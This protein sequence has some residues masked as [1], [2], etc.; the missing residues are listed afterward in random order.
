[1]FVGKNVDVDGMI[2]GVSVAPAEGM[3][4]GLQDEVAIDGDVVGNNVRISEGKPFEGFVGVALSNRV[5]IFV[6]RGVD[7]GDTVGSAVKVANV[8]N[9]VG[10]KV[11]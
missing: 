6:G 10:Y 7:D 11:G 8:G 5:G 3:N 2:V 1:L 4:V 9:I